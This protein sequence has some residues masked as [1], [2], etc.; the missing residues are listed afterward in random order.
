MKY[1]TSNKTQNAWNCDG[2]SI[3]PIT[4]YINNPLFHELSL[5][6][7]YFSKSEERIYIDSIDR[8]GYTNE[9]KKPSRKD[10]KLVLKIELKNPLLREMRLRV[11][12]YSQDEYLYIF[13]TSRLTLKYKTYSVLRGKKR[14]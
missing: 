14:K 8:T 2:F 4:D 5:E 6:D 1:N 11:W 9:I 12:G 10:S 3:A 7:K 13:G